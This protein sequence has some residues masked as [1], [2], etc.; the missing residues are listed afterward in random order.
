MWARLANLTLSTYIFIGL[1]LGALCGLFFGE[2][3]RSLDFIGKAFVM[4]LQMAVLPFIVISLIHGIGSLSTTDARWIATKG[5]GLLV[6]LWTVGLVVIFAFALTFPVVQTS[7]FFSVSDFASAK[8]IDFL[9]TYIPA[10]IFT[11]LSQGTVPAIVLFSV[12]LGFSLIAIKDKE[13]FLKVLSVLSQGL[14]RMT[15][16]VIKTAPL[17][18]FALTASAAGTLSLEQLQRL[19]VYFLTFI[20]VCLVLTFWVLPAIVSTFTPFRFKDILNYSKDA[21]ILGFVSGN[22]FIILPIIAAKSKQLFQKAGL[23]DEKSDTMVD[24]VLPLAYSFPSVG[25]LME[26]LF[27]I[28]VAWY[29]NQSI[30]FLQHLELAVA[31]VM[32]LFGSPKVGV[33]F[34][35]NYM[36]LPSVYFDLYLVSDVVTRKFKVMLQSMSFQAVT[37]IL[38]YIVIHKLQLNIR[39]TLITVGSTIILVAVLILATRATLSFTVRNIYFEDIILMS[40]E[41]GDTV[42]NKVF[43]DPLDLDYFRKT[44][45]DQSEDILNRIKKRGVLRVGYNAEALPFAFF[46]QRNELVGYDIFFAHRL[47]RD[48]GVTVDFIPVDQHRMRTYLAEGICDII[49][50]AVPITTKNLGLMN[51]TNP[52]MDMNAALIVKDYR[53]KDFRSADRIAEMRNLRIA[54]TPANTQEER[55]ELKAAFR[56]ATP[57]ELTC[58]KDFFTQENLADALLTTDKI[59]KTWALLYPEF[60]V[61]VPHPVLFR[62]DIAYAVPFTKGDYVFL[63]YL[64]HWL[65]LQNTRGEATQQFDYWILGKTPQRKVRRWSIIRNVLHWVR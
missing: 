1:I 49:M 36:K 46:N 47:A 54:C 39:K 40:M 63:E 50:S 30:G 62:Y 52:Y 59:G 25:R 5:S 51:F 18:V 10:N 41:I 8:K 31:G 55:R 12:F 44:S 33:P 43:K 42:P 38:S 2:M 34:L 32:S 27:I 11:A 58:I 9:T 53:K 45:G 29:V 60:G 6:F 37:L 17:G 65:Q 13:P 22:N 28:F 24:S 4:L 3:C 56:R 20:L 26:L 7:S 35:L 21:L 64:N 48:L 61:A 15:Q 57:E 14:S 19:H 23:H 16:M